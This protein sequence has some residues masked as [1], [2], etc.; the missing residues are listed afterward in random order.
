MTSKYVLI[1]FHKIDAESEQFMISGV[2]KSDLV[3]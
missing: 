3:R 1:I 2:I